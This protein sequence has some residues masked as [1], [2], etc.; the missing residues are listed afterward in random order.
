MGNAGS[1]LQ[2]WNFLNLNVW[3]HC[4]RL[5]CGDYWEKTERAE[6]GHLGELQSFP[7]SKN[8][9]VGKPFPFP[10]TV[11]QTKFTVPKLLR[12]RI[13]NSLLMIFLLAVV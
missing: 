7:D 6:V 5:K 8:A 2:A 10:T 1:Q 4:I 11:G 12:Q 13:C 9:M 3:L